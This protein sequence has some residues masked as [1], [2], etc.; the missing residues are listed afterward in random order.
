MGPAYV[1]H[2]HTAT[3]PLRRDQVVELE[4]SLWPGGIIFDA[5]E[6]MRLEFAGRVQILQDFDGVNEHV[7][8]YNVGR[9]RLHTGAGYESQFLVNLWRS[10]KQG[11]IGEEA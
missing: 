9:H 4:I 8:N 3:Q 5:G 10:G 7:V 6:S 11:D 1:Y 2:P